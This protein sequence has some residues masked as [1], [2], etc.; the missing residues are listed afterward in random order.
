MSFKAGCDC[1]CR[2]VKFKGLLFIDWATGYVTQAAECT[3]CGKL[4][5]APAM[6]ELDSL[7]QF[8]KHADC[9]EVNKSS[10][11]MQKTKGRPS[12]AFGYTDVD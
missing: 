5:Q 4:G 3:N 1:G 2:T 11:D 12:V 10:V 9:I 6:F 8:P 7:W